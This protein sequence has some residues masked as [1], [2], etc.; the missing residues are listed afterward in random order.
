ME[1]TLKENRKNVDDLKKCERIIA[2]METFEKHWKKIGGRCGIGLTYA[3]I[4]GTD[5][6]DSQTTMQN[7]KILM[8]ELFYSDKSFEVEA[9][10]ADSW[11]FHTIF[12]PTTQGTYSVDLG[13]SYMKGC[14]KIVKLVPITESFR[15]EVSYK[16]KE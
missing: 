8:D 7:F 9:R 1:R 3:N 11:I 13:M 4:Y 6:K 10:T 12:D 16:C 14:E 5:S 2:R 15:E